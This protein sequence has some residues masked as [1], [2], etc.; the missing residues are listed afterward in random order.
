MRRNRNATGGF[1]LIEAVVALSILAVTMT[2]IY[3][4]FGWTLR[5][6]AD[7]RQKDWAWQTAQS[8]LD[9]RRAD[10]SLAP[11]HHTGRTLQGSA[12]ETVVK[13]FPHPTG[14]PLFEVNVKVTWREQP[15]RY[16]E[17]RSLEFGASR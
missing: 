16:V 7:Q 4:I 6:S 3:Q 17:L 5:H 14:T 15:G 2:V 11:G 10:G 1:T 13:S 12:W 9:Q 8:L